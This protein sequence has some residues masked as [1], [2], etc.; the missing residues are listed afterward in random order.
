MFGVSFGAFFDVV[1]LL[2]SIVGDGVAGLSVDSD[3]L[4]IASVVG[5]D[6]F[7]A[8]VV[9]RLRVGDI[10]QARGLVERLRLSSLP[11]Q[12]SEAGWRHR[13]WAGW[14]TGGPRSL[15]VV[16]KVT[17]IDGRADEDSIVSDAPVFAD[18]G[19]A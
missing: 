19:C 17:M 7:E 6:R 16:V 1:A 18:A 8:C 3:L 14:Y 10:G 12:V 9:V 11:D 4:R 5:G 13:E 15:P 2:P